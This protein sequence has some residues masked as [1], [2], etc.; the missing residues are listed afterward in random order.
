MLTYEYTVNSWTNL[1]I[2]IDLCCVEMRNPKIKVFNKL[3]KIINSHFNNK[4]YVLNKKS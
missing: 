4:N 2:C 3:L 1:N